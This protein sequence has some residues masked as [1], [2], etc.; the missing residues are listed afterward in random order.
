MK[1]ETQG[2]GSNKHLLVK[3]DDG[4]VLATVLAAYKHEV[5]DALIEDCAASANR[6]NTDESKAVPR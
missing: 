3:D 2:A 1:I 6:S 4:K 5:I